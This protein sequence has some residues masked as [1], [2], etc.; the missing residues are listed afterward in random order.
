M[1]QLYGEI[2]ALMV[3]L[4]QR[5]RRCNDLCTSAQTTSHVVHA[6][7]RPAEDVG[8]HNQGTPGAPLKTASHRLH[9]M[10]EEMVVSV[11]DMGNWVGDAIPSRMYRI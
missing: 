11:H 7:W 1:E 9:T 8:N 2:S 5:R 10:E 4:V 3:W 6:N